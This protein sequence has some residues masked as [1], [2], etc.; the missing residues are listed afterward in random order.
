MAGPVS[1]CFNTAALA[2]D[3]VE[4]MKYV[5][6]GQFAYLYPCH[7]W[8]KPLNPIL[9]ETSQSYLPDGTKVYLE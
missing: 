8:D 3:P 5:I 4:R 9:G 1:P 2:T 7:T 6:V